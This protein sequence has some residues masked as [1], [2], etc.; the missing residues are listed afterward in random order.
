MRWKES[1]T[2]VSSD[3]MWVKLGDLVI[4]YTTACLAT[5]VLM[6]LTR[7]QFFHQKR[8][9]IFYKIE[10]WNNQRGQVLLTHQ[11]RFENQFFSWKQSS[12]WHKNT[13]SLLVRCLSFIISPTYTLLPT[14]VFTNVLL[15]PASRIL[16]SLGTIHWNGVIFIFW[17]LIGFEIFSWKGKVKSEWE[18]EV[19]KQESIIEIF[20]WRGIQ[21]FSRMN[22]TLTYGPIIKDEALQK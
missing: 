16:F 3:D 6:K 17:R 20:K 10:Q 11:M 22:M 18:V 19:N 12:V 9:I 15:T 21:W 4:K 1:E 2:P 8:S 5:F 7:A 14:L 13:I